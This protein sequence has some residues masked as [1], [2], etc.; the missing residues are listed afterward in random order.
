M[1]KRFCDKCGTHI[2]NRDFRKLSI[3]N[4]DNEYILACGEYAY[5]TVKD[6]ELCR[7]CAGEILSQ[8]IK[9]KNMSALTDEDGFPIT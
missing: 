7:K 1:I 4:A 3:T 5:D 8:L 9:D 6:V 2:E